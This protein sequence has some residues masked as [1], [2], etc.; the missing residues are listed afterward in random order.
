MH[1]PN[2]KQLAASQVKDF[3]FAAQT[4]KVTLASTNVENT[5]SAF[6]P[7]EKYAV[8]GSAT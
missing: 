5:V 2:V 1:S 3:L 6:T 8:I 7:L 4:N